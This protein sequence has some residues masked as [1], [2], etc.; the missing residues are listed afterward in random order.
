[1]QQKPLGNGLFKRLECK[2][3]VIVKVCRVL[4]R[5]HFSDLGCGS[6]LESNRGHIRPLINEGSFC[7]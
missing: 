4:G 1:M 3:E 6:R 2:D 7:I 5:N